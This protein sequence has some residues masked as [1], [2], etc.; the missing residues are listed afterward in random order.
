MQDDREMTTDA[1]LLDAILDEA[2]TAHDGMPITAKRV[3]QWTNLSIKTISDY[4][5][6]LINIPA[7]FWSFIAEQC[8]DP[9]I[10]GLILSRRTY[11]LT[12]IDTAPDLVDDVEALRLAIDQLAQFHETQKRF[13]RI[14]ADGKIDES[15][16]VEI[17][18]YNLAFE[19]FMQISQQVH[20]AVNTAFEESQIRESLT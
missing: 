12:Y 1:E 3:A 5:R 6:G 15:D 17:G 14:V 11:R 2:V 16:A 20:Y 8:D 18:K 19:A 13:A 7:S 10:V 4:R 9:R